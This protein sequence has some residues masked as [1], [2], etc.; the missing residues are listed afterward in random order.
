[1]VYRLNEL[2]GLL[3]K[4]IVRTEAYIR[5]E[6]D[7]ASRVAKPLPREKKKKTCKNYSVTKVS[8]F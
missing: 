3:G 4:N 8:Y 1:M 7:E 2:E 5:L 6:E